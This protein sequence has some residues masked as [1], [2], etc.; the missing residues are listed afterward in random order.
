MRFL[1]TP[2]G[3][4]ATTAALC[5]YTTI[6]FLSTPSGWRATAFAT[7][8]DNIVKF[9]ST[10]SGWRATKYLIYDNGASQF[11]STPSGWRA[12]STPTTGT[13]SSLYFY[14]RPPGGGRRRDVSVIHHAVIISI[15]ALRVEG[16][17]APEL[18]LTSLA[19]VFLSTPS[20]WRA[21]AEPRAASWPPRFLSTPSGWR[22][23][24]CAPGT[25]CPA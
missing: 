12:T 10:P 19:T 6:R 3:W 4:R 14:P 7:A 15:H 22:A 5:R 20:G 13:R 9:L 1:S 8:A 18:S 24:P 2:S 17:P 23:T 21:T 16:D 25:R 11:L